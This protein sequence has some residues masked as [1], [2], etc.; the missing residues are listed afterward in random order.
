M[1]WLALFAVF[2]LA[3]SNSTSS[4]E[5]EES[6]P[7]TTSSYDGNTIF[8]ATPL[9]RS[10]AN[11]V[12]A[13]IILESGERFPWATAINEL[14]AQREA[15]NRLILALSPNVTVFPPREATLAPS[16]GGVFVSDSSHLLLNATIILIVRG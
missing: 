7:I 16:D 6:F 5:H 9:M 4:S 8:L 3:C 13:E 1:R 11:F 14:M 12:R 15:S 10:A 2:F